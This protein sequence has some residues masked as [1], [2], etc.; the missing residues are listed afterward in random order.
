MEGNFIYHRKE[1]AL[2]GFSGSGKTTLLRSLIKILSQEF[3]VGYA[4]HDAHHFEIDHAKKDTFMAKEAGAKNILIS[5]QTQW[6]FMGQGPLDP[7]AKKNL[8]KK[9]DFV[10]V[11]GHKKTTIP[12]IVM[13]DK[14]R[15]ILD[16]IEK[17]KITQIKAL[18]KQNH[19]IKINPNLLSH[20]P[21]FHR[22]DIEGI[23]NFTLNYFNRSLEK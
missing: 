23:K 20:F 5:N 19:S 8:F 3:L 4:K 14:D 18:C 9:C 7:Q 22:D 10:L 21:I 6:A 1:L 2:C 17:N 15:E 12:K 13:I 11:E 16:L